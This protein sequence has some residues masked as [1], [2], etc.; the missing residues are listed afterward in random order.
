MRLAARTGM[1]K[2]KVALARKLA[3]V[4]R[5]M[6]ADGT[7]FLA[8]KAAAAAAANQR[9]LQVRAVRDTFRPEQGPVAGTMDQV[10]PMTF[11]QGFATARC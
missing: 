2:G 6:L 8:D 11:Q 3:V 10:R 5:R 1:R 7:S 9:R 4:L